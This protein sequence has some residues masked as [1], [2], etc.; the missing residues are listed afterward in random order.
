MRLG[1]TQKQVLIC[2]VQHKRWYRACGWLWDTH[3]NTER[4]LQ[5]MIKYDLVEV[6]RKKA[7]FRT[8]Y[9]P[10]KTARDMYDNGELTA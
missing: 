10:T 7:N 6:D 3:S 5:S 9:V 1:K 4:V 2:L 8:T